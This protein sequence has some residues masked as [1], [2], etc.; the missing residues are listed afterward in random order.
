VA[1]AI[2]PSEYFVC[3]M[4]FQVENI[5][6]Y[7]QMNPPD[8][9]CWPVLLSK[10][11]GNTALQLC[12]EHATHGNLKEKVHTRPSKF[13][14]DYIYANFARR[15]TTSENEHANWVPSKRGRI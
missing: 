12:P 9:Y 13:D 11:K 4:V 10:K 3:G 8:Q 2:S 15:P 1:Y 6:K 5:A 14:L 7:Y